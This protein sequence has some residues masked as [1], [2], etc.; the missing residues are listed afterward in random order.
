MI[1]GNQAA[2]ENNSKHYIQ[3]AVAKTVVR[4]ADWFPSK[5]AD[6]FERGN[7]VGLCDVPLEMILP[8]ELLIPRFS[9]RMIM[10]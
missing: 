9:K 3:C 6:T 8:L 5:D 10:L 4:M 7:Y 1:I 2:A